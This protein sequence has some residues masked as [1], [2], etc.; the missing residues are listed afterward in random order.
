MTVHQY[1]IV[2]G[3]TI[4]A[5]GGKALLTATVPRLQVRS[6]PSTADVATVVDRDHLLVKIRHLEAAANE[7]HKAAQELNK[8]GRYQEAAEMYAQMRKLDADAL[9]ATQELGCPSCKVSAAER[10]ATK[11]AGAEPSSSPIYQQ[12]HVPT[13]WPAASGSLFTPWTL[14]LIDTLIEA[15]LS[16]NIASELPDLPSLHFVRAAAAAAAA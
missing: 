10:A 1:S 4:A 14:L 15:V 7:A 8:Q 3:G 2:H 16:I 12:V 5:C 9:D 13:L 11:G 6:M